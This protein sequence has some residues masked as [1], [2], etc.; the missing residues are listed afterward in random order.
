[1]AQSTDD[2]HKV[3]SLTERLKT[4]KIYPIFQEC[5]EKNNI[6]ALQF[7]CIL[8]FYAN[9]YIKL[10]DRI[11]GSQQPKLL[12][13]L[14]QFSQFEKF[15]Y[16]YYPVN[17]QYGNCVL[18]CK[19][20]PLV[21]PCGCILSH[22][23][24]NHNVHTALNKCIFCEK[25]MLEMHLANN[26]L[27]KCYMKYLE[28]NDIQID[29]NVCGIVANFYE[30]LRKL[31]QI[32][33]I[34]STRRKGYA[35]KGYRCNETLPQ[36]YEGYIVPEC[37]VRYMIPK[38]QQNRSIR[39]ESLDREFQRI[40]DIIY[41]ENGQSHSR[42]ATLSVDK[43]IVIDDADDSSEND[44]EVENMTAD[45]SQCCETG[46]GHQYQ[47]GSLVLKRRRKF[48]SLKIMITELISI[49][50]VSSNCRMHVLCL[51]MK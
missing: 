15:K 33:N 35:G 30:M 25:E 41:G 31:S 11:S 48:L 51:M 8:D 14:L 49:F 3:A 44:D 18:Q 26:S 28:R 10:Y 16:F 9:Y 22:M 42:T 1:M 37:E 36:D 7:M 29:I 12:G 13:Q 50:S 4:L 2:A 23:V 24:I 40:T 47:V 38:N 17:K 34:C 43:V 5:S 21:G 46:N 45:S 20:C 39:S 32:L 27:L 6:T 19:Y